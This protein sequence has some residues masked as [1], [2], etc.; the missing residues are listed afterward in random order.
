MTH[1]KIALKKFRSEKFGNRRIES[2]SEGKQDAEN[3]SLRAKKFKFS[4]EIN[5]KEI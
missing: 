2:N 5:C 1:Y 3:A 4:V